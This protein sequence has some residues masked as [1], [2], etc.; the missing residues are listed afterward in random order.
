MRAAAPSSS[1]VTLF[2]RLTAFAPPRS[3]LSGEPWEAFVD[4]AIAQGLAPLAAYN[5]EYRL[6]G[7]G[8]PEWAR[9][10]LLTVYQGAV[11]DVVMKLVNFKRSIDELAGCRLVLLG[12]VAFV[13]SLYPHVAFRPLLDL[14]LL[15]DPLELS[16][17]QAHLARSGFSPIE[18]S[19]EVTVLS[20]RRTQIS[21]YTALLGLKR[22]GAERALR[23][24][25]TP[26]KLYGPSVLRLSGEDAL[27]STAALLARHGFEVPFLSFVDLREL[28]VGAPS[29][30]GPYS[31]TLDREVTAERVRS[32]RLER[33]LYACLSIVE[34]LF[35]EASADCSALRPSLRPATS[36]LLE[37]A[38]I[39]PL[40]ELGHVTVV[41][42]ATRL[43]R[44]LA[45]A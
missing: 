36:A 15:V 2:R 14:E 5:L 11:N 22:S 3:D 26:A 43:R 33:A 31:R 34:R 20:D 24:R 16:L 18:A 21:L 27:L 12:G 28:V 8:A 41:R 30:T 10:R 9:D 38:L 37:R 4:W 25:A 19:E 35:P 44:L 7:A 29:V 42:G 23:E 13:D 6:G 1:L 17:V 39:A 40:A 32:L 45:G